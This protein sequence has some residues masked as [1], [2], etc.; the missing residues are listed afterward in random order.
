MPSAGKLATSVKCGKSGTSEIAIVFFFAR[1][2]PTR[3]HLNA[4]WLEHV[5]WS[6]EQFFH[7]RSSAS[8]RTEGLVVSLEQTVWWNSNTWRGTGDEEQRE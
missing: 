8:S 5:A 3:K 4:D 6:Y 1:D 2:W 7:V